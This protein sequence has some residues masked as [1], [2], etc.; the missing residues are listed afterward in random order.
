MTVL[1]F[2]TPVSESNLFGIVVLIGALT[3][4][5]VIL[6]ATIVGSIGRML[7]RRERLV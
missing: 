1:A 2:L 7:T 3:L 4:L 6:P 5:M